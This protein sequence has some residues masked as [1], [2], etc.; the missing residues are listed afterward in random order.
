MFEGSS[1]EDCGH[2]GGSTSY[3]TECFDSY[4]TVAYDVWARNTNDQSTNDDSTLFDQMIFCGTGLSLN[5]N[6]PRNKSR[7]PDKGTFVHKN[8]D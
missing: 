1:P 5:K 3:T 8:R 7:K 2:G 6:W 4:R